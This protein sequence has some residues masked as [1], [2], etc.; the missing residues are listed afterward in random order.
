MSDLNIDFGNGI[1]AGGHATDTVRILGY[2]GFDFPGIE[3]SITENAVLDG[4]T[5][6]AARATA[7][8]MTVH[9]DFGRA[10]TRTEIASAFRPNVERTMSTA[11]GSIPY[12]VDTLSFDSENTKT[13]IRALVSMVS[14]LGYAQGQGQSATLGDG[15]GTVSSES[16]VTA[17]PRII[18]TMPSDASGLTISTPAG[19]TTLTGTLLSGQEVIVDAAAFS[20]STGSAE[21][22][23][24]SATTA[25][26]LHKIGD[27]GF[28]FPLTISAAGTHRGL[29]FK[30]KETGGVA[31]VLTLS[32]YSGSAGTG[33]PI[34]TTTVAIPA[35]SDGVFRAS[36]NAA[37][38][39]GAHVVVAKLLD[40]SSTSTLL[41]Y[42]DA[43]NIAANDTSNTTMTCS[44]VI[45]GYSSLGCWGYQSVTLQAGDRIDSFKFWI[46]DLPELYDTDPDS[47]MEYCQIRSHG[48]TIVK[49]YLTTPSTLVVGYNTAT[50][51]T[52]YVVPADGSYDFLIGFW[53]TVTAVPTGDMKLAVST[54][55]PY[56]SGCAGRMTAKNV[57]TD[58]ANNDLR[59]SVDGYDK[60]AGRYFISHLMVGASSHI[61]YFDRGGVFPLLNTG[62]NYIEATTPSGTLVPLSIEWTPRLLGLVE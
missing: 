40:G 4:A 15:S 30:V 1:T 5:V 10:Y 13:D 35:S 26:L 33:T 39:A 46:S 43:T 58:V 9:L 36:W 51:S 7:R 55:N 53:S 41:F 14:R 37:V 12:K 23:D 50:L 24:Q 27:A 45:D 32:L 28:P 56:A 22:N 11:R 31:R 6:G 18:A 57:F 60:S 38:S 3:Q 2:S 20:V 54:V 59:F 34:A 16:D 49:S 48:S 17:Y 61:D 52:P 62:D 29:T 19:D 42:V 25:A 8:R 47:C 44:D 21:T